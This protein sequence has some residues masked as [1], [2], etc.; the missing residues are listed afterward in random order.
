MIREVSTTLFRSFEIKSIT[1][2]TIKAIDESGV[3]NKSVST[4]KLFI[5]EAD[6][7][8][9]EALKER[10][11]SED[12]EELEQADLLRDNA[13]KSFVKY[14]Q[15]LELTNLPELHVLAR[16]LLLIFKRHNLRLNT[17]SFEEQSIALDRFIKDMQSEED[18]LSRIALASDLLNDL[19]EKQKHFDKLY[20]DKGELIIKKEGKAYSPT[21]T[22]K[23]VAI[24][25]LNGL[26][27]VLN[28]LARL[29]HD[30]QDKI[31]ELSTKIDN[32]LELKEDAAYERLLKS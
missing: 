20:R 29:E 5:Q 13:F 12:K 30:E 16:K 17:L 22:I 19:I 11:I 25:H 15:A 3:A 2:A 27:N 18:S 32:L 28:S 14:L 9:A 24:Q 23:M 21:K 26:I 6:N 7:Y 4:F 31:K 8:L 10:D 1:E